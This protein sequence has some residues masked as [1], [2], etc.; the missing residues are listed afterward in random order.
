MA[1]PPK[2]NPA[3][4]LALAVNAARV[5]GVVCIALGALSILP[6]VLLSGGQGSSRLLI[7]VVAGV[8]MVF[9]VP[10][11]LYVVLAAYLKNRKTWA[12]ITL[13]AIGGMHAILM[14]LS[15]AG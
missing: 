4:P 11:I 1:I 8:A 13:L 14:A 10:G 5:L 3:R 2:G 7:L 9:V 12:A 6:L 15:L